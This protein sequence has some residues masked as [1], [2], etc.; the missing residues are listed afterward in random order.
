MLPKKTAR[1]S[2]SI[3]SMTPA[4]L[5]FLITNWHMDTTTERAI[6]FK[7]QGSLTLQET[8]NLSKLGQVNQAI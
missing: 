2:G 1:V 7:T 6:Q 5:K 3:I 4:V 8:H